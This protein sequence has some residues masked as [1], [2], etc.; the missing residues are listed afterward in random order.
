MDSTQEQIERIRRMPSPGLFASLGAETPATAAEKEKLQI[1][2]IRLPPELIAEIDR[3][4][5]ARGWENRSTF[6]RH[7]L[8][9]SLALGSPE[10]A[11]M[12]QAIEQILGPLAEQQGERIG[13]LLVEILSH[14]PKGLIQELIIAAVDALTPYLI[15]TLGMSGELVKQ[16]IFEIVGQIGEDPVLGSQANADQV[17]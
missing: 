10:V 17:E 9:I 12:Q 14:I 4:V 8:V 3:Q 13:K 11:D 2:S 16:A 15:R 7:S 6:I 1:T 5:E